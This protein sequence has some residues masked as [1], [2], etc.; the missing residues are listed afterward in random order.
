MTFNILY[1]FLLSETLPLFRKSQLRLLYSWDKF[2][3]RYVEPNK[4][5]SAKYDDIEHFRETKFREIPRKFFKNF[6]K[7]TK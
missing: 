3:F 1:K 6:R 5:N 4:R 2:S 7:N